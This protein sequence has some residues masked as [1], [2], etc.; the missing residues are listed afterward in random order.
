MSLCYNNEFYLTFSSGCVAIRDL[1][2][3]WYGNLAAF[4]LNVVATVDLDLKH[5]AMDVR[6]YD[7]GPILFSLT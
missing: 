6:E 2:F 3:S 4:D 5:S 7:P 1:L